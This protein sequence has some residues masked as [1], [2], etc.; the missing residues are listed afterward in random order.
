MKPK[1]S[2]LYF[3]SPKEYRSTELD[4]EI[5]VAENGSTDGSL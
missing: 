3:E 5:I 4:G 2:V 1:P